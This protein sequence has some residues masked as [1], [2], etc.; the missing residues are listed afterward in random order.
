MRLK[1]EAAYC[2]LIYRAGGMEELRVWNGRDGPVPNRML[3]PSGAKASLVLGPTVR[4]PAYVPEVGERIFVA[5]HPERAV[6]I[7]AA[8]VEE[9]WADARFPLSAKY[10]SKEEAVEDLAKRYFGD[11]NA[12]DL[13]EVTPFLRQRYLTGIGGTPAQA[14]WQ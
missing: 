14:A 1:Y 11:G 12:P 9:F 3:L 2:H 8:K 6:H 4:V 13:V 10:S 5:L 7:A